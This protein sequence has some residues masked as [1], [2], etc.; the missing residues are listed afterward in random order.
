LLATTALATFGAGWILTPVHADE[1]APP[2]VSA[3]NFKV[4]GFGGYADG[5]TSFKSWGDGV[6]GAAG[7]VTIPLGQQFGLQFDGQAG[8][9]GGNGF[10]GAGG[11]AFWRNPN[12][13]M[14]GAYGS[15]TYLDRGGWPHIA[16]GRGVSLANGAV[17]GE[18]YLDGFT[19]RGVAGVEGGDVPSRF[20]SKADVAYYATP[21]LELSAGYRY[22]GEM[23]A[24]ALGAEW[25]TPVNL[26]GNARLAVFADGRVGDQ[27]Y[28]AA[29]AG[30]R[31]YFGP[32]N[33]LIDKHRR[34]DPGD[35]Q[36]D[37]LF[38]IQAFVDR[39]DRKNEAAKTSTSTVTLVSDARLKRDIR[40]LARSR[41]GIGIYRFRYYG[42]DTAYVGVMAQEVRALEPSAVATGADGTLRVNYAALGVRMV[43]WAD[44]TGSEERLAA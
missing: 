2:A 38:G 10:Y 12:L 20:F 22:T 14:I 31:I 19:L 6:G 37:N 24:A 36:K 4:E 11:H 33:V 40:L 30:V 8:S 13:G 16:R 39:L 5:K 34:D 7:A 27:H 23:S 29:L 21:D 1:T 3:L 43:T 15:W 25:L 26:G 9:W 18:Y 32:S 44:W 28:R 17:E 42:D 41:S 35:W